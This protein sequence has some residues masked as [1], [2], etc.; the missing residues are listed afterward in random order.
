MRFR[1]GHPS[2]PQYDFKLLDVTPEAAKR[3]D[4]LGPVATVAR[5]FDWPHTFGGFRGWTDTYNSIWWPQGAEQFAT[6]VVVIDDARNDTLAQCIAQQKAATPSTQWRWPYLV[7]SALLA[8]ADNGLPAEGFTPRGIGPVAVETE[9]MA[10]KMY[11]LTPINISSLD[12]SEAVRGLWLLP[13][14]DIRYFFRNVPLNTAGGSSSSQGAGGEYPLIEILRTEAPDW[15]PPLR[16]YPQDLTAP[17][18]YV[19]IA[20]QGTEGG[21]TSATPMGE[22]AD[23]QAIMQN[24]RVVNRDV[25]TNYNT[26]SGLEPHNQF[27]GVVADYPEDWATDP[28]TSYHLDA[29]QFLEE[30]RTRYAGGECDVRTLDD[31]IARKLQ[32]VFDV[33]GA[34]AVY[35][36]TLRTLVDFPDTV[37]DF[38]EDADGPDATE[39]VLIPI[40]HLGPTVSTRYPGP[41]EHAELVTAAKQWFL[42][43]CYW[44]RKQAF[45]KFPGIFPVI[46]NGHAQMIRWDFRGI[47]CETTYIALEGVRG[48]DTSYAQARQPFYARIDGEGLLE[49]QLQGVYA[50]TELRDHDGQLTDDHPS[51]RRGYVAGVNGAFVTVNP[52]RD[53]TGMVAVPVGLP[54]W[55]KP[56]VPYLDVT[57]G[58]IFDHYLFT[59]TN[60][61]QLVR[62]KRTYERSA[63]GFI[64]A[65]I[66]TWDYSIR[67][68]RDSE[69]IWTVFGPTGQ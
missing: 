1:L 57:T 61:T 33:E 17:M 58:Q 64:G 48:T 52:A 35:S 53:E 69:E 56:G 31:L 13:L 22:A 27:T 21:I 49:D 62:I 16:A 46:P 30:D 59:T 42:L 45:V 39:K 5:S 60:L 66:Q 34:G 37:A 43:Y 44:R 20:D 18:H 41:A 11:P 19:A 65:I 32:F 9:L 51:P 25:R 2:F 4:R 26:P 14:V 8:P 50:Y 6:C 23:R 24:W 28:T 63:S 47:V 3:I 55:L 10:W 15:M 7:L 36:V 67:G 12:P 54:V 40:V 29:L 68:W 38:T